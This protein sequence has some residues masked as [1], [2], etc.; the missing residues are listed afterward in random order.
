MSQTIDKSDMTI[1]IDSSDFKWSNL[2]KTEDYWAVW[3]GFFLIGI[4]L[5]IYLTNPPEKLDEI[6]AGVEKR[7][8]SEALK[9]FRTLAWYSASED[10][11]K[12]KA[13]QESYAKT[14]K[15]WTHKPHRWS[16]N[17]LEAF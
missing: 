7:L 3:I 15:H 6:M 5:G 16:T 4:G 1:A 9:P 13:N 12:I 11:G 17:P 14:I 8:S 10:K 2:W